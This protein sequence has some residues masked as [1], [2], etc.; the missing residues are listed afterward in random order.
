MS[1]RLKL[2]IVLSFLFI[3]SNALLVYLFVSNGF[4]LWEGII[5]MI[6]LCLTIIGLIIIYRD[7]PIQSSAQ[8]LN[9][10]VESQKRSDLSMDIL[11]T[12]KHEISELADRTHALS[13]QVETLVHVAGDISQGASIQTKNVVK[14]TDTMTEISSGIQQIAASSEVVS[15]T[16]KKASIAADEGNKLIGNLLNQMQSMY[17]IT[18][19][20]S[21]F[22]ANLANH[23]G[24]V[25]QI[26]HSITDIAEQ[27][28]LLSF[29]A[30]IEA[31]RAGEFGK[32]FT[33]VANEVGKLSNK[34]KE[35]TVR[36]S[37]ILS[38]IQSD[39]NK[40]VEMTAKSMD[41]V[42]DGMSVMNKT[43]RYFETIIQEVS[44]TSDQIMEVTAAVQQLAASTN[45]VEK[46]TEFTMKVQQGGTA[47]INQLATLL[48]DFH[49]SFDAIEKN[50]HIME[51]RVEKERIGSVVH[52]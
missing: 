47:K 25:D 1:T 9:E 44:G 14:S 39:V 51:S 6:S 42:S 11:N 21:T 17:K 40:A 7:V 24:E 13:D 26:V 52:E 15:D 48:N 33:V 2:Y 4:H 27:T 3:F 31:A 18:D 8:F 50:Y 10:A 16:S 49:S 23:S 30:H 45:E 34:S 35:E 32:G 37:K 46:I 29:N 5:P 36:I 12:T 41:E 38:D 22:V 28:Q 19:Q 43:K 20:L